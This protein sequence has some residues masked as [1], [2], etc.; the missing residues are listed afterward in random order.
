[1]KEKMT[2]KHGVVEERIVQR[3]LE[4]LMLSVEG[5]AERRPTF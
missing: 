3:I 4:K 2:K 5:N 1:M